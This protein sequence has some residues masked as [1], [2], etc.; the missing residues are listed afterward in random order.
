[1][2]EIEIIKV[3]NQ[4]YSMFDDMV[5]WRLNERER[6]T[7]EK[8]EAEGK[9]FRDVYLALV[10]PNLFVYAALDGDKFVGWISVVYI[11]KVGRLNGLGHIYVDELWVEPTYRN[12]GVAKKLM[13][14]ADELL[15]STSSAGIRLYV[16]TENPNAKMLY[17]K[18]GFSESGSAYFMEK[19]K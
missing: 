11:P 15:N 18:C 6:T 14:K 4:N 12:Q 7:I 16:N 17:E 8:A 3:D 10:N 5:F 19:D 9:D 2:K 13:E 1:M